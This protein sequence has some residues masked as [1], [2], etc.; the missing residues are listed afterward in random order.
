[1]SLRMLTPLL[2]LLSTTVFA[3][4][5]QA[6]LD[7]VQQLLAQDTAFNA[8]ERQHAE[9]M[10]TALRRDAPSLSAPA[11]QLGVAKLFALAQNG[12]TMLLTGLWPSQFNRIA[13]RTQVFADG[14]FVLDADDRT[15]IGQKLLAIDGQPAE[16]LR[17][18]FTEYW[19]ALPN[20]CDDWLGYWLESAELLH[21]AGLA[22][23]PDALT[24]Q[25]QN[26][27]GK[28]SEV[29]LPASVQLPAHGR[30]A[31]FS[32]SRL[33]ELLPANLAARAPT[34]LYLAEPDKLFRHAALPELNAFYLQL[35]YNTHAAGQ[36]LD[37]AFID[38]ALAAIAAQKPQHI[39]VDL[40]LNSGGDLNN[41]RALM[42][43]LPT[44]LPANGKIFAITSG[45]TFS[46]GIASL[47]YL[48]QAGGDRVVIVGEPVGDML[49]Y[50]AEGSLV[51]L[52]VSKA[53]I[54]IATE[55]HNYVTGCQEADC[56]G[57]IRKHP[58]RVQ[59]LAPDIRAPLRYQ[60]YQRGIDPA[61]QAI[62]T[63]LKPAS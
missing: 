50:W 34:P 2:A 53:E 49:E 24:L 8:S 63:A 35:R 60:D 62:V 46:A 30:Y 61:L 58:I 33:V 36:R 21:A 38:A 11:F 4:D 44:L 59:S 6:D 7:K 19:G 17:Q 9:A 29:T 52:P 41:T 10:L 54:L 28:I 20:K 16:Q 57:S 31:F 51:E 37:S 42:Q 40:R 27:K 22:E 25:V 12:H 26:S 13:V 14:I 32:H 43:T 55:R 45:R 56:H 1:M 3:T 23:K 5:Y 39:I 18:R 47:G 15:L 48:K